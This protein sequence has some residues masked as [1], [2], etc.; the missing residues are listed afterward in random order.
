MIGLIILIALPLIEIAVLIKVGQWIGFWPVLGLVIATFL[1]GSAILGRSGLSS[2][3]K[4]REALARGEPPVEAMLDSSM[5]VVAAILLITPGLLADTVGILL[6]IPPVR[7]L[8]AHHAL[9]NALIVGTIRTGGSPFD[10][11]P[12]ASPYDPEPPAGESGGPIIDGEFERLD[13]RPVNRPRQT[14]RDR[15]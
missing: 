3:I 9:R 15:E 5:L 2:A 6:L 14:P 4:V 12:R 13:E 1:L 7:R 8:I 11:G 10:D